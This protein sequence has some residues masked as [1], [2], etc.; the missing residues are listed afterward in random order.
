MV[1]VD[2]RRKG[3]NRTVFVLIIWTEL[4][5][6]IFNISLVLFCDL[7]KED[8]MGRECSTKGGEDECI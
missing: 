4:L 2:K 8:E 3:R 7:V 5:I 1:R 6:F